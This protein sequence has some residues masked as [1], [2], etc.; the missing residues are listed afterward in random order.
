MEEFKPDR[1]LGL[2]SGSV[3]ILLVLALDAIM[4]W[5]INRVGISLVAFLLLLAVIGRGAMGA[6]DV[7]LSAAL[8]VLLGYPLIISGLV[9]GV[10]AGGIAALIILVFRRDKKDRFMA[11]GPYLAL[12][13]WLAFFSLLVSLGPA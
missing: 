1:W 12:G 7:K 8:G 9:L 10:L 3:L 13:G 6:G 2:L 5:G 4:I 11:Y